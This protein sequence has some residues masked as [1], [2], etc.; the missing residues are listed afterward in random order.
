MGRVGHRGPYGGNERLHPDGYARLILDPGRHELVLPNIPG[1]LGTV[2]AAA[3]GPLWMQLY[4]YAW[5]V[6][7]FI[8]FYAAP[9]PERHRADTIRGAKHPLIAL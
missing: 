1:F 4:D 2:K 5:F 3:V 9:G 8:L 6:G 7:F